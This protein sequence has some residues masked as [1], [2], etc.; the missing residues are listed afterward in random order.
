M[1][2]SSPPRHPQSKHF[3]LGFG[4]FEQAAG[5]TSFALCS[6]NTGSMICPSGSFA[7]YPPSQKHRA[8]PHSVV[9][10][11]GETTEAVQHQRLELSRFPWVLEMR[12]SQQS[13]P[14][15]CWLRFDARTSTTILIALADGRPHFGGTIP[16][17][18]VWQR[19]DILSGL[20]SLSLWYPRHVP[21]APHTTK[22]A[23]DCSP[24]PK[25]VRP[26]CPFPET[27]WNFCRDRCL[28]PLF[29]RRR[30]PLRHAKQQS[31]RVRL[32]DLPVEAIANYPAVIRKI[33]RR[34]EEWQF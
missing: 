14:L 11:V 17:E 23:S 27:G 24:A 16:R 1:S 22:G 30:I 3:L 25:S 12:S 5:C 19:L 21:L 4:R 31:P 8:V 32:F 29:I 15:W 33:Q 20:S 7:T 2:Q 28:R 10:W 9:S 34:Q 13:F 18:G 26:R 6:Q